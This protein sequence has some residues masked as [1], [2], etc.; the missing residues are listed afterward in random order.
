LK[1]DFSY[2]ATT[3]YHTFPWCNPTDEQKAK[4]DKTAQAIL[5]ARAKNAHCTLA[6]LYGEN[7]YLFGGLVKAHKANDAAVMAA[8]GFKKDMTEAEIVG[9]LFKLYEKLTSE[10][11]QN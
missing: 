4:I 5:D 7:A 10:G 6:Q 8:Y 2:G 3:V 1:S 9:E 11:K